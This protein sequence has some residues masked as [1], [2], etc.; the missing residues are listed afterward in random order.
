MNP[1]IMV[2]N[3]CVTFGC[4]HVLQ[5][6]L[7]QA[8]VEFNIASSILRLMLYFINTLYLLHAANGLKKQKSIVQCI[9]A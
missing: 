1:C 6:L 5:L 4:F 9:N 7:A 2:V 3:K 8:S